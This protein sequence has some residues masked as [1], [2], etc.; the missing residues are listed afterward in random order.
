[1]HSKASYFFNHWKTILGFALIG[2][3]LGL[4]GSFLRPLEYSSTLSLLIVPKNIS[5]ADPYTAL[6]SIDRIA[7]NLSQIVY[8][9][10]FF[11]KVFSKS[12]GPDRAQFGS[13]EIKKRK[14]WHRSVAVS[15]NRGTG[16]FKITAYHLQPIQARLLAESVADVLIAEGWQYVGADFEIK[17]VDAPL[18]SR[19]PVRP[20]I[21]FVVLGSMLAGISAGL[22][23]VFWHYH[24]HKQRIFGIG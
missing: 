4:V 6:R 2:A 17:L 20:N 24:T 7:D 23:Y 22:I 13:D 14:K 15:I 8:T 9:S 11:D 21:P 1:M 10:T 19:Y 3:V 5:T 12:A 18:E 16:L